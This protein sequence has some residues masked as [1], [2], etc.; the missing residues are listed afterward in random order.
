LHVVPKKKQRFSY[1]RRNSSS[2]SIWR[3]P[4]LVVVV[5]PVAMVRL[6][7]VV[8]VAL[9]RLPV[10][11]QLVLVLLPLV[12]A[13]MLRR[14]TDPLLPVGNGEAKNGKMSVKSLRRIWRNQWC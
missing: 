12:V 13:V 9:V 10:V 8:E 1:A 2:I 3:P 6:P 4:L 14:S 7:V 5:L 11:L